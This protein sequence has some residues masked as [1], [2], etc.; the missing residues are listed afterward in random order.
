MRT[1]GCRQSWFPFK[2]LLTLFPMQ[3]KA[4]SAFLSG[5]MKDTVQLNPAG[6]YGKL[7][8]FWYSVL[9]IPYSART[10]FLPGRT[11]Q[12]VS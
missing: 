11:P 5:E 12:T 1:S 4:M 6:S 9:K 7:G 2:T 3:V 8:G 10:L